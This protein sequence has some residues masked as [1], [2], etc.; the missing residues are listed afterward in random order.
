MHRKVSIALTLICVSC[1]IAAAEDTRGVLE[2]TMKNIGDVRC[3]QYSGN[4]AAFTLGQS[5]S[6][7]SP[8]PRFEIKSFTRAV[9]YDKLATRQEAVGAQ[10]PLPSQFLM[11]EKAWGQTGAN[12]MTAPPPAVTAERR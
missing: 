6:P 10:G 8:W 7:G 2:T 12:I 3:I 1:A 9:D 11:G 5:V 4:G